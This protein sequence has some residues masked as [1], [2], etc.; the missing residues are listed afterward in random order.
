M[1]IVGDNRCSVWEEQFEKTDT[2][3][4]R[5]KVWRTEMFQNRG[6]DESYISGADVYEA[7]AER[8]QE[9]LNK[10]AE[11]IEPIYWQLE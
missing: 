7:A 11:D 10:K 8:V 1:Q 4:K 2:T 3:L 5:M 9:F 6:D